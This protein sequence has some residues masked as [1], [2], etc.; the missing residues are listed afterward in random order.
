MLPLPSRTHPKN[1]TPAVYT[2]ELTH[3]HDQK[4]WI[5]AE[6]ELNLNE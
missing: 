3:L 5:R 2:K 6:L 1:Q 4:D